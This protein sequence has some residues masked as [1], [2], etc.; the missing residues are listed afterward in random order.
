[1]NTN[2]FFDWHCE[3]YL[4][5]DE[6][7]YCIYKIFI[8]LK[9]IYSNRNTILSHGKRAIRGRVCNVICKKIHLTS[10][11]TNVASTPKITLTCNQQQYWSFLNDDNTN[12]TIGAGVAGSGKTLIAVSSAVQHLYDKR[13]EKII[14]TR[15]TVSLD[16][17]LGYLPG[18]FQDKMSPFLQPIYDSLLDYYPAD[19]LKQLLK[20][21][22][23]E[24]CPLAFIRGRTFQKCFILADEMQNSTPNQ[25]KTFLTR[26]GNNTKVAITGDPKQCDV[27]NFNGLEHFL[28]L[29][30]TYGPIEGIKVVEMTHDDVKRSEIVKRLLMLY[31]AQ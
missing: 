24:V 19:S 14:I 15:P 6:I 11:K 13:V 1:M 31:E 8:M 9:T 29:Y 18:T 27:G 26:I 5:N 28:Y 25:M 10:Q 16:E 4:R 17:Q 12:I 20:D 2:L 3:V 21:G 23:I 22:I 30:K 7:K